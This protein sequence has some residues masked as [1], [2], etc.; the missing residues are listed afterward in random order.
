MSKALPIIIA[1]IVAGAGGFFGGMQYQKT[2]LNSARKNF[3]GQNLTQEQRDQMRQQFAN[4]QGGGFA[5]GSG[6]RGG[7]RANAAAAAGEI[8]AK[9]DMSITV[10]LQGGGSASPDPSRQGRAEADGSQ[11]GSKI[12]FYS[13]STEVGKF[14]Q[15][16]ADDL[17]VGKNVWVTGTANDDG[18]L[19]AQ[20]IQIRPA[21]PQP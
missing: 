19:T 2:R 11:G 8:I 16:T 18:S 1:V 9:D 5:G 20:N 7:A 4:G 15:G 21:L 13:G 6:A 17:A 12:V 10:K 3:V 14:E